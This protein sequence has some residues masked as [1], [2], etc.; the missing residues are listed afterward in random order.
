MSLSRRAVLATAAATPALCSFTAA[1]APPWSLPAAGAVSQTEHVW[2]P[3]RDGV[4]LSARLFLPATAEKSAVPGVL[5]YIPYRK[6]DGYRAHDSAWG[7]QLASH[8]IAYVRVDVRGSGD[9]EGVLVDEYDLPEL[10]DGIEIIAWI[11][12]QPWC[13]G[14]V[15]MRGISWGGINTLHE[16][17]PL[18]G[19][20]AWAHE[21]AVGRGVQGGDGGPAGSSQCRGGLGGSLA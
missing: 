7:Q 4:R 18:R 16:R 19:G 3:M 17:R 1:A 9:S 10:E 13:S 6:R 12:R 20:C 2:I 5:E 21:P 15:G 8:G 14:A 11:A